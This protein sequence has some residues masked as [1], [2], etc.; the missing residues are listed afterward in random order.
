MGPGLV[1]VYLDEADRVVLDAFAVG[2]MQAEG[3][4]QLGQAL[5]L[6]TALRVLPAADLLPLG[7][8]LGLIVW[9]MQAPRGAPR[10]ANEGLGGGP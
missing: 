7:R 10:L 4:A 9:A 3:P 6:L 8:E 5:V 1:I 2:V